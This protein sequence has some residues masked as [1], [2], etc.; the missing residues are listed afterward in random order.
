VRWPLASINLSAAMMAQMI[1]FMKKE[2]FGAEIEKTDY[3]AE[4]DMIIPDWVS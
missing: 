2:V 3:V 1:D 4:T